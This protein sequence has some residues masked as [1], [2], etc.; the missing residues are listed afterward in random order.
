MP[1][2]FCYG[3]HDAADDAFRALIRRL[4]YAAKAATLCRLH[5]RLLRAVCRA[6]SLRHGRC[7]VC[8]MPRAFVSLMI[9]AAD[10][11]AAATQREMAI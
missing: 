10:A 3:A 1:S 2:A 6:Y 7:C 5:G 4:S 8:A 9:F 11:A